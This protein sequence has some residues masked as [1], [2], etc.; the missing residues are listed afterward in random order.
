MK[1]TV[2]ISAN[3]TI[4][5]NENPEDRQE[6]EATKRFQMDVASDMAPHAIAGEFER[7]FG[8]FVAHLTSPQAMIQPTPTGPRPVPS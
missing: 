8:N 2:R 7:Q 6:R 3:I 1:I 5:N 4:D